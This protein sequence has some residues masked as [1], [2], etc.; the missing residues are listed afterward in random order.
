[1]KK[2]FLVLAVA[3]MVLSGCGKIEESIDALSNRIDKLEQSVPTIEE[4]ISSIQESINALEEVDSKLKESIKDLEASDKATAEE[5][6]KLKNADKAIEDKIEELKKYVDEVLKSTK[7]WVSATF[8]TLEQLN[9]L[10]GE[11]AALKSLV[12]TNKTE[13]AT[14]LANAISALET[15]LKS[16]VGEQ[17]ANY[18]TIAEVEAKITALQQQLNDLKSQLETAKAELTKAYKKAIKEAIE[19]NNGVIDQKIA[20]EIAA[21]NKRIDEEMAAIEARLDN[22]EAQVKDLLARI[23]SVSYIPTYDDGKA[24]VKYAD[25]ISRV[26]LDFEVSPKDAVAELTE[27]WQSAVSVKAIY[28]QT[29]AISFIDMPIVKFETDATKGV[30]SVTASGENLS[31]EFFNGTQSTSAR[32]SISDGNSSVTSEYVPMVAQEVDMYQLSVPANQIWYTSTDDKIVIPYKSY[33]FGA[34][35]VSNTYEKGIGIIKFDRNVTSIGGS[36]FQG[37]TSLKRVTIPDSVTSIGDYAFE[38]CTSLKSVTIPDS[39]TKIGSY[40][41]YGCSSLTSVTI[42]NSVTSIGDW[43]F[44]DCYS[45]TAFY[46]KFASADN[47]CLII[48]GV[49]KLFAPVGLTEYTI[50]DSVTSIGYE[51]FCYCGSLTSV[52]IPDSVTSIGERAFYNCSSLTSV[53]IPNSVTSIGEGAFEYCES[54]TSVT[55]PDSVTSIGYKAFGSC[56][57]ELVV[58]SK[59]LLETDYTSSK[60]NYPTNSY[61]GWLYGAKFTKLTIGDNI[62]KIGTYAF[63]DCSRLT[64]VTIGNSVTS[65]GEWAFAGCSSLISVTIP[66]S[67]T[68]IG[69]KAFYSCDSLTSVTIGNGVTSIGDYAFSGCTSLTSVYCKPTTPPAGNSS[70]FR[71]NASGRKIYVPRNSVEAYKAA[72]YWSDYADY[73]EGYDF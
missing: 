60:Y 61:T 27:V 71:N 52:T 64:S 13:A 32:L 65:I 48:N 53:T 17:L 59:T 26:T 63:V 41:F 5:I 31:A 40:A 15:S 25:K 2:L 43:A 42:G 22:V 6:A 28:T 10:A 24:T 33:V 66:D 68:S 20:S 44:G 12:D 8:A 14:N 70:M 62:T 67:V 18:Y 58:N 50:P 16:W 72:Q 23:Q 4:Q 45:L 73:I 3:A 69:D 34:N 51:A 19:T 21:V 30:I 36:A 54:L 57:G 47:R 39:V 49:L 35:I 55:I 1:M 37:C 9:A 7:D 11:V 29:R 46:G 38:Y 56:S